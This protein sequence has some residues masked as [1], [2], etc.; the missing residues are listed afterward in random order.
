MVRHPEKTPRGD[1]VKLDIPTEPRARWEWI[2]YQIRA[3][4]LSLAEL[5]RRLDVDR[6]A[7]TAVKR[8]PYPRMERAIADALDLPPAVIWP[9]R[10]NAD[11]T[12]CRRRP[13]RAEKNAS[14]SS[15]H[16]SGSATDAHRQ[17]AVEV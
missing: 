13:N 17:R 4:G 5:A 16:G 9:E 3:R 15:T 10:W 7:L 6:P 14:I 12:P 1:A 11:G 8:Y 2:K